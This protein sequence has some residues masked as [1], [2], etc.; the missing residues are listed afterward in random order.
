[1][2]GMPISGIDRIGGTGDKF[3]A[4]VRITVVDIQ[5]GCRR[6][7]VGGIVAV[8]ECDLRQI[9]RRY[10]A[11]IW[12]DADVPSSSAG[13]TS[14]C[15]SFSGIRIDDPVYVDLLN[16]AVYRIPVRNIRLQDGK[17]FACGIPLCDSP[18]LIADRSHLW[19]Y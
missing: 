1:M 13:K 9:K 16:G 15:L 8:I 3:P 12:I 6:W 11:R 4:P 2:K 5:K 14:V 7:S 17:T 10:S 19:I 18:I